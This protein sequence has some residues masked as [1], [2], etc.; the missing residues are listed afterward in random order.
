MQPAMRISPGTWHALARTQSQWSRGTPNTPGLSGLRQVR[1]ESRLPP[2]T[3]RNH[4]SVVRA[5]PYTRLH[6]PRCAASSLCT[7]SSMQSPHDTR[8]AE[9]SRSLRPR[10]MVSHRTNG[11]PRP[12][13]ICPGS[14]PSLTDAPGNLRTSTRSWDWILAVHPLCYAEFV[15]LFARLGGVCCQNLGARRLGQRRIDIIT[16]ATPSAHCVMNCPNSWLTSSRRYGILCM[17]L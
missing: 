11:A 1:F 2:P 16:F 8:G 5:Y 9:V 14:L 4:L 3:A 6:L 15:S 17:T 7:L 13:A 10:N 12:G